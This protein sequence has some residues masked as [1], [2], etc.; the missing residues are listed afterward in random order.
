M[1]SNDEPCFFMTNSVRPLSSF[2][3]AFKLNTF[4]SK[5]PRAAQC[6]LT[7]ALFGGHFNE[8]RL[9]PVYRRHFQLSLHFRDHADQT[10]ATS[11][12]DA[13]FDAWRQTTWLS[14]AAGYANDVSDRQQLVAPEQDKKLTGACRSAG[15]LSKKQRILMTELTRRATV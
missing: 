8:C 6:S 3:Y 15:S 4:H 1:I 9:F 13:S 5:R 2:P 12:L 10:A 14:P 7:D 11:R